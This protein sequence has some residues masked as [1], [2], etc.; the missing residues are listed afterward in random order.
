MIA[1]IDAH[2]HV[3]PDKIAEKSKESVRDFYQLPMY[4]SGTAAHLKAEKKPFQLYE[5]N[6]QIV[7][8]LIFTPAVTA[9]VKINCFTIC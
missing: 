7:K 8:Q 3:F 6:Y 2:C 4:T 5:Q 9:G 1:I